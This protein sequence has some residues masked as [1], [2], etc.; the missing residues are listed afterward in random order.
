[1]DCPIPLQTWTCF[2]RVLCYLRSPGHN[3]KTRTSSFGSVSSFPLLFLHTHVLVFRYLQ[4]QSH[5]TSP[6]TH[7]HTPT[8]TP[9][10]SLKVKLEKDKPSS[11]IK[12]VVGICKESTFSFLAV[13][14][15]LFGYSKMISSKMVRC[16]VVVVVLF[17]F[18]L[19]CFLFFL[20]FVLFC[21]VLFCFVLF[22]FCFVFFV[23]ICYNGIF[24]WHM[25]WLILSVLP[26]PWEHFLWCMS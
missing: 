26:A 4:T 2:K 6:Q 20:F 15:P 7:T 9:V 23:S 25:N 21:F 24:C 19:F 8:H 3:R 17:C 11:S 14:S 5:P 12:V 10:V 13:V 16:F 22:L 1:M 18:V